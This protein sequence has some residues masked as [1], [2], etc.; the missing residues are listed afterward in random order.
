MSGERAPRPP[1]TAKSLLIDLCVLAL[2]AAFFL[3]PWQHP[4]SLGRTCLAGR[5]AA[6]G[7]LA[8]FVIVRTKESQLGWECWRGAP[9]TCGVLSLAAI[10]SDP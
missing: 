6:C 1:W 4:G 9:T 8:L 7:L 2:I 5:P 10:T 3:G